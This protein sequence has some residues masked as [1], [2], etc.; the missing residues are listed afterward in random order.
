MMLLQYQWKYLTDL[1]VK[2]ELNGIERDFILDSGAPS[3]YLN[4]KYFS[5]T[6]DTVN[7]ISSAQGVSSGISG[8]DVFRVN[9]F[10]FHG[11]RAEN[12]DFVMSDISHLSKDRENIWINWLSSAK[13]LRLAIR[14]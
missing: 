12:T 6:N 3:L 9:T 11:I 7:S 14:L 2:A 10:N 13:G 8:Q 4:S 1:F 5:N